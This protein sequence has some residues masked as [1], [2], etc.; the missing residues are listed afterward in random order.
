MKRF[1]EGMHTSEKTTLR[2]QL[3]GAFREYQNEDFETVAE[4]EEQERS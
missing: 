2:I 1:Y 4:M 3:E